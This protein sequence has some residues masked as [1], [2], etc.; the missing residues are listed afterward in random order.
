MKCLL[1]T[2]LASDWP[3]DELLWMIIS[4]ASYNTGKLKINFYQKGSRLTSYL[5]SGLDMPHMYCIFML[6]IVQPSNLCK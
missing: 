1:T 2:V 5:E 6:C 4:I 3:A